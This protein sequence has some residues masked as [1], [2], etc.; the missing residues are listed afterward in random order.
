[1]EMIISSLYIADKL[2]VCEELYEYYKTK[3]NDDLL[4]LNIYNSNYTDPIIIRRNYER[5]YPC[6]KNYKQIYLPPSNEII[7]ENKI[8]NDINFYYNGK[9]V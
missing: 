3:V 4:Y 2:K 1:M 7:E 8:F 6:K 9:Y 5:I